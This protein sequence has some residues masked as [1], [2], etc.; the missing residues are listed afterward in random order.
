[1]VKSFVSLQIYVSEVHF[2]EWKWNTGY[3]H[4]C[5][6]WGR[7]CLNIHEL[8]LEELSIS[9]SI[10]TAS[11]PSCLHPVTGINNTLP[12]SVP[13]RENSSFSDSVHFLI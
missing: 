11:L 13:G 8:I 7:Y 1:M 4:D 3:M 10:S 5:I 9:E 12:G 6:I 2:L